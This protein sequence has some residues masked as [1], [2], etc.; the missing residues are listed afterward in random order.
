MIQTTLKIGQRFPAK[1][2][3]PT[4]VIGLVSSLGTVANSQAIFG[5]PQVNK[6]RQAEGKNYIGSMNR[7][8]QA[9]FLEKGKFASTIP[10]LEV[11]VPSQTQNYQFRIVPQGN[12]KQ[13]VMMTATPKVTLLK[14]YT[15]AVFIV[16]N[17]TV[18][19][20]CE[21][22]RPSTRP[23]AMPKPPKNASASSVQCP[24]GSH[25]V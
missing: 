2:I 8:Q 20:I 21:S 25:R 15:G 4:I 13:R 10:Q 1:L 9:Y 22:D 3:A 5:I 12:Q 16:K 17:V 19:V 6:A 24:A 11:G 14:S 7:G 23:P 18:A